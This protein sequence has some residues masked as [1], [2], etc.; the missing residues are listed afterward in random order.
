MDNIANIPKEHRDSVADLSNAFN[1]AITAHFPSGRINVEEVAIACITV[2]SAYLLR[3]PDLNL[4]QE[5][6]AKY[7]GLMAHTVAQNSVGGGR[8]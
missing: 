7:I 3:I 2:F 5:K 4:R 6:T 1:D 8:G